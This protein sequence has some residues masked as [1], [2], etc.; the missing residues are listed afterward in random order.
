MKFASRCLDDH[1]IDYKEAVLLKVLNNLGPAY[2]NFL[3]IL[4]SKICN[5][6]NN[7][8]Y[9]VEQIWKDLEAEESRL[10]TKAK[11]QANAAKTRSSSNRSGSSCGGGNSGNSNNRNNSSN[12]RA[13]KKCGCTH[14]PDS[15]CRHA[16]LTCNT[17]SVKGHISP[18]HKKLYKANGKEEK[19][20]KDKDKDAN[21]ITTVSC[22][23]THVTNLHSKDPSS[24]FILDSGTTAHLIANKDLIHNY[25]ED[26]EQYQTGSGECLPSYGKGKLFI[27]L[28]GTNLAVNDVLYAPDLG[29]N[30]ISPMLLGCKGVETYL[31]N[32]NNASQLLHNSKVIGYADSINNQYVL[33]IKANAVTNAHKSDQA[34]KTK[35]VDYAIWHER[36]THLGYQNLKKLADTAIGIEFKGAIPEEICEGCMAGC[37]HCQINRIP[38]SKP[39]EFLQ[40]VDSDIAGPY[41]PTCQGYRYYQS[42]YNRATGL[43]D[44]YPMKHKSESCQNFKDFTALRENQSNCRLKT[45]HTDGAFPD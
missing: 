41:P 39:V 10:E 5:A 42:F 20:S 30:L 3:L 13:C 17:C 26:F 19:K 38:S 40:D 8:P 16:E 44:I 6:P 7:T 11:V 43:F 33:C 34:A 2:D 27:P 36:M 25:Y 1:K 29:Y 37:Q 4:S 9:S 18:N 21:A 28:D 35:P 24:K 23:S 45:I 14:N 12:E 15:P 31:H 32:H 22:L